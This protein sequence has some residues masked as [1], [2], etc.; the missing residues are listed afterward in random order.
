MWHLALNLAVAGL[1]GPAA[2]QGVVVAGGR[3]RGRAFR[4]AAAVP[5]EGGGLQADE[6]LVKPFRFDQRL[7]ICNAYPSGSPM[8]VRKNEKEV[9]ADG[10]H[11]IAFRECRYVPAQLRP[12]DKLDM[13]LRDMEIHGSFEVEDQLPAS[14]AVLLLVLEK[15]EGSSLI[16]FQSLAFPTSGSSQGDAQLAVIDTFFGN[17]SSRH[18]RMED[19]ITGKEEQT[20]SK[21]VEQLS[22]NR[23]YSIEAGVYDASVAGEAAPGARTALRLG[24]GQ[25]YVVI[26]TGS[27]GAGSVNESL[28]VFPDD[29]KSGS[30]RPAT[31][32]AWLVAAAAVLS[33][34][35]AL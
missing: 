14:D 9:L 28:V 13:S 21:R 33:A 22:F 1:L 35:R 8:V 31:L 5:G 24:R 23:V 4:A 10:S 16:S 17:A 29:L 20:V 25:N 6:G 12:H 32:T 11:A 19:H 34:A 7:L 26:R 2:V 30:G 18:L 15:H 3:G 27:G